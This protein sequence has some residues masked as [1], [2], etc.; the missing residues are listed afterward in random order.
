M[1]YIGKFSIGMKSSRMPTRPRTIALMGQ[2]MREEAAGP[3][4]RW[5][6]KRY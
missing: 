4:K 3:R 6:L 2:Q 5:F 1:G